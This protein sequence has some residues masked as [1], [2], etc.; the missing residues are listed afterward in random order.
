MDKEHR[1]YAPIAILV[2]T[3]AIAFGLYALKSKNPF[4]TKI[5][6]GEEAAS[7]K[8]EMVSS[9]QGGVVEGFPRE[10]ILPKDAIIQR[11][12]NVRIESRGQNVLTVTYFTNATLPDIFA[13][14][15][16]YL[17][18]KGFKVF[19]SDAKTTKSNIAAQGA[20]YNVG[21]AMALIDA[22]TLKVEVSVTKTDKP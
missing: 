10:L 13:G 16:S 8:V 2:I 7:M 22:K 18:D 4:F 20:A 19:L 15:L 17:A 1:N 21:V 14:Y 9:I 5:F 3:A 6:K 11:S 12:S